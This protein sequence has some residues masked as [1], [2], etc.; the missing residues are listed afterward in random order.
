MFIFFPKKVRSEKIS[1]V[2]LKES[3]PYISGNGTLHLP[4][5]VPKIFPYKNFVYFFL[6]SLLWKSF[7]YFLKESSLLFRNG[8]LEKILIFQEAELS[9]TSG[10][11]IF[12]YFGKGTFRTL[13]CLELET[14]SELWHIQNHVIFKTRGK[15]RTL[16]NI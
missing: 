12:L 9:Y 7:L 14:Y 11:G 3:F 16:S 15:F 13:A 8:N 5:S 6:K 10:N 2:F 4:I 1:C